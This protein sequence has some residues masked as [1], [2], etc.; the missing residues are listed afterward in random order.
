ML[1]LEPRPDRYLLYGSITCPFTHRVLL[2]RALRRLEDE[3]PVALTRPVPGPAGWEFDPPGGPHADPERGAGSLREVYLTGDPAFSGKPSVP[4][5][6]D[7][8]A[9]AGISQDSREISLGLNAHAAAR[10]SD[11]YP[12]A[13]A[14]RIDEDVAGFD[15]D[16]VR[17]IITAGSTQSQADYE[18]AV[19][20]VFGWL[21]L[22]DLRLADRRY[23]GGR[24]PD[25]ADLVIFTGLVRFDTCYYYGSRCHLRRVQDYPRVWGYARDL[26]QLPGVAATVDLDAFR[27]SYFLTRPTGRD[28]VVPLVPF[29]DFA[30]THDRATLSRD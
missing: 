9:G 17:A 13:S 1:S 25:L 11:L 10:G 2:A 12:A 21:D 23:L 3:L 30:S 19:Q 28:G 27:R 24:N 14:H 26:Y 4:L 16:F 22:L 20:G 15:R 5:L 8:Q 18:Q 29:P 6:W 7:R